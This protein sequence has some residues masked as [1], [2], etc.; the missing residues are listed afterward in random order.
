MSEVVVIRE[1]FDWLE[2]KPDSPFTETDLKELMTYMSRVYPKLDCIELG[3]NRVKFINLVGTIRLSH[4]QIDIIPKLDLGEQ[5]GKVALLNMLGVCG[6]IPYKMGPAS[7]SV[8]AV[9][10][11]LLS[12]IAAAFCMELETQLKKG[13]PSNYVEVEENLQ[14]LKGKLKLAKHLQLNTAVKSR[15]YCSFDERTTSIPLNLVFAK[16]VAVLKRKVNDQS[17]RKKVLQLSGYL[18]ELEEMGDVRNLIQQI[19]FNRQTSRFEPAFRLAKLILSK[20]SVLHRGSSEECFSFL[21]E[22]NSLYEH[23]VGRVLQQM[24]FENNT[25]IRLQHD[26]VRLLKNEDSGRDNIQLIPDIVIGDQQENGTEVWKK[27]MDTKW[28][29]STKYQQND[30]YQMYAYVTGYSNAVSAILLYPATG[31]FAPNRNWTLA[32]DPGKQ[33]RA[34]TVRITHWKETQEDLREI[35]AEPEC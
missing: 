2:A 20:M 9:S 28:K 4:V 34:R 19:N 25:V 22:V 13:I 31:E 12:W 17:V 1:A 14:L 15:A 18:S 35:L 27:I 5:D 24:S 26:E 23:Y 8:Q 6:N 32:A 21:F 11:D 33:I 30:I 29:V 16:T 3:Y 10:M 7:A